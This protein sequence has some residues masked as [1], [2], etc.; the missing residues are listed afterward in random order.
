M[1]SFALHA[2][3]LFNME[4]INIDKREKEPTNMVRKRRENKKKGKRMD[5][6]N[7]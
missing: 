2:K 5:E 1:H 4:Y 7:T 3:E 6:E